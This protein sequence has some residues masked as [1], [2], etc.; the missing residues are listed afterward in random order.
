MTF[1]SLISFFYKFFGG[2]SPITI[3]V[4]DIFEIIQYYFF[5][6]CF[7]FEQLIEIQ[8]ALR[9]SL[10]MEYLYTEFITPEM[11][12]HYFTKAEKIE[13]KRKKDRDNA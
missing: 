2:D 7:D 1:R 3:D 13:E 6:H 8:I 5:V 12:L 9:A 11:L 4:I 10:K